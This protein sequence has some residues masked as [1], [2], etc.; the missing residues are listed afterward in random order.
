MRESL[1]IIVKRGRASRKFVIP[2]K[3]L[4]AMP[5]IGDW[6]SIKNHGDGWAIIAIISQW[7]TDVTSFS[8]NK[9]RGKR[10]KRVVLC[11][12]CDK[13]LIDFDIGHPEHPE[14]PNL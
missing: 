5:K 4:E 6:V 3:Q 8:M 12:E 7:S 9:P 13:A 14:H 1:S 2:V 10:K 11:A